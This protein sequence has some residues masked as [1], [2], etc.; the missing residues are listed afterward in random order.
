MDICGVRPDHERLSQARDLEF[1]GDAAQV[2]MAGLILKSVGLARLTHIEDCNCTLQSIETTI[3]RLA[4]LRIVSSANNGVYGHFFG[5][6]K[7]W[8]ISEYSIIRE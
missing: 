7:S 4:V 6:K 2:H 3:L 1:I 5:V 8:R